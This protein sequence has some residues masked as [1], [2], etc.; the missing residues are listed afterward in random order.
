MTGMC[1]II[2]RLLF[3][4]LHHVLFLFSF[5][6]V[7]FLLDFYQSNK[8]LLRYKIENLLF[9]EIYPKRIITLTD[10]SFLI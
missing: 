8:M 5:I 7:A 6:H 2:Y 9:G 3:F 10:I 4:T 1:N